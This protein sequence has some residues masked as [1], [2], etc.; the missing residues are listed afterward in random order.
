[1]TT[2]KKLTEHQ[3]KKCE[4]A[5]EESCHCRC[6]GQMHGGKRGGGNAPMSFYYALP[7]DDPHYV[8]SPER[9]KE[10]QQEK[11]EAKRK[12]RQDRIDEA[13]KAKQDALTAYY[14]ARRD[15]NYDLASELHEKFMEAH[16]HAEAVR[17]SK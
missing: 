15:E 8:P 10:I 9:R 17:K 14:L 12:E 7:V 4:E 6:G 16:N 5:R 11:R 3:A 2:M 13:E 1:M